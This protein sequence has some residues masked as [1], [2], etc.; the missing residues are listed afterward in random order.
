MVSSF[1]FWILVCTGW[2]L[3]LWAHR[4]N[5]FHQP[6]R[7]YE[8][9]QYTILYLGFALSGVAAIRECRRLGTILRGAW[10]DLSPQRGCMVLAP[11]VP[12][13]GMPTHTSDC[14]ADERV[15][16]CKRTANGRVVAYRVTAYG[17]AVMENASC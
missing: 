16:I 12:R 14:K 8:K 13:Y 6:V 4:A 3:N 9:K 15:S 2:R 1:W 7:F 10:G 11:C 5:F 17:F